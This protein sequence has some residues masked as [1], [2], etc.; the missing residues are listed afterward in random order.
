[1]NCTTFCALKDARSNLSS[2]TVPPING[3]KAKRMKG[4]RTDRLLDKLL[5]DE[6]REMRNETRPAETFI[7][8][9]WVL[10]LDPSVQ[11]LL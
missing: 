5:E 4:A 1:M 9:N 11:L 10:Y 2:R 3:R 6:N 7:K 8:L